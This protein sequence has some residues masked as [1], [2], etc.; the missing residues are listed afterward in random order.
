MV[1][2]SKIY[3][4]SGDGGTTRLG[5]G[6]EVSKTNPRVEAYGTV[7]E[8]NAVLG[9]VLSQALPK[10][11]QTALQLIQNDPSVPPPG[12]DAS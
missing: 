7:D 12:V 4:K 8:L 1:T 9:L 11:Q 5:N 2:L 3:T 10:E 6:E